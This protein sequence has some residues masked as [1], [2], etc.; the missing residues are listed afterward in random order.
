MTAGW[1]RYLLAGEGGREGAVISFAEAHRVD[2]LY[3]NCNQIAELNHVCFRE[4]IG[5]N[6]L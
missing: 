6:Y 4:L 1:W 5:D 2:D 3:R